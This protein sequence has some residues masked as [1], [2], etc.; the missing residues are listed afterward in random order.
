VPRKGD[1]VLVVGTPRN[2]ESAYP[3]YID[4][5]LVRIELQ[6]RG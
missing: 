2:V 4:N 1:Q 5:D 3:I 6:V